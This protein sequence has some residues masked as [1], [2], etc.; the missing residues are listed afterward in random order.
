MSNLYELTEAYNE[1]MLM[2]EDEAVNTTLECIED[3]I[4]VKVEN[5]CKLIKN[6]EA[7]IAAIKKEEE[8]LNAK[9]KSLQNRMDSLNNYLRECMEA[10]NVKKINAGIFNPVLPAGVPKLNI[11]DTEAIPQKYRL[12]KTETFVDKKSLLRDIKAL[13]DG[14]HMPGVELVLT[15]PKVRIK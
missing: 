9:R 12:S 15:E 2:E 4:S 7:D 13:N 8:R 1:L 3:D 6:T 14:E 10:M 11:F 5:I